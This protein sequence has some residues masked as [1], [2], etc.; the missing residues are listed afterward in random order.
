MQERRTTEGRL[1]LALV[2]ACATVLLAPLWVGSATGQ[3]AAPVTYQ[4][5]TYSGAA[6]PSQDKPQSK[7]WHQDGSWWALMLTGQGGTVN[8]FELMPDHS[9]RNTGSVVDTRPS[10]TGD[11]LWAD[12]RLYVASRTSSGSVRVFRLSY[13]PST[14][15]YRM[16]SGFPRTVVGGGSESVTITRDSNARLWITYTQQSKVWLAH[17]TT[18]DTAWTAPFTVPVPDPG[19]TSDDISAIVSIG[20]RPGDAT[21]RPKVG[22]MWSDQGS[23]AFRFAVHDDAAL[24][25]NGLPTRDWQLETAMA[26]SRLSDDHINVKGI[27]GGDD[28]RIHAVVKTGQTTSTAPLLVVLTRSATG[29]W[30]SAV[31]GTV[32]DD[33]TRGQIALD[34]TNQMIY[35][36]ATSPT[37]GSSG[38]VYY[39]RSPLSSISFPPGLGT[40]FVRWS[41]AGMNNVSVAKTPVDST[42]GLVGLASAANQKRYYHAEMALAGS[43]SVPGPEPAPAPDTQPPTAPTDLRGTGSTSSSLALAWDAATDETGVA[44]YEVVRDGTPVATTTVLHHTDSGL[45]PST[46]Y[47]YTVVAFD[48]AGNRS[49]PSA[50][51]TVT[52]Q[53]LTTS[54]IAFRGATTTK[55]T[56]AGS[57]VLPHPEEAAAGDVLVAVL[58]ARG[59]ARITAPAGWVVQRRDEHGTTMSQT[60]LSLVLTE[61]GGS[62]TFV[63]S[64]S[65]TAATGQ[66]LA[67]SGVSSSSPVAWHAGQLNGSAGFVE[68]PA[69]VVQSD[70]GVIGLFGMAR[71]TELVPSSPLTGRA[72]VTTTTGTR[73]VAGAAGDV[74]SGDA[75]GPLRA[76]ATTGSAASIGQTLVLSPGT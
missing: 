34:S 48:A 49:P 29:S 68:A 64:R 67:Y 22:V 42:T 76:D 8:V 9:W 47:T 5:P 31:A 33:H 24:D 43:T 65:V 62:S 16:D 12:G 28:G 20:A 41:G 45:T 72:G 38:V 74:L 66:V 23:G 11:A 44:G 56:A 14:R 55:A 4:G 71:T 54:T 27:A 53:D 3:E 1:R 18:S 70:Q 13:E 26:G 50:A 51:L 40:P 17:S 21:S 46:S 32:S 69:P 60:V 58:S 57:L 19:V 7:L 15:S 52:T 2:L 6:S 61:P 59:T 73:N 63:F 10:S 35:V 75:P 25:A 30:S 37:S 36:L 39:K